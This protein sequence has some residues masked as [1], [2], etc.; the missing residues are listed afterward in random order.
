MAAAVAGVF[1][2]ADGLRF[3]AARARLM[4]SVSG[5]GGMA[6]VMAEEDQGATGAGRSTT[7]SSLSRR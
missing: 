3:I 7:I 2:L 1:S 5:D 4:Q 6:A